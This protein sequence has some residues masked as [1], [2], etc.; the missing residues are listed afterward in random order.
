MEPTLSARELALFPL[1]TVL[2]PGGTLPLQIFEARYLD[3]MSRCLRERGSAPS[4]ARADFGIVHLVAGN[5]VRRAGDDEPRFA[6]IGTSVRIEHADMPRAGLMLVALRG[7]RRFRVGAVECRENGLWIAQASDLPDDPAVAP[8][9][10]HMPV[11]AALRQVLDH[12]ASRA[13]SGTHALDATRFDDAAW[14]AHRWCEL[15]PAAPPQKQAWLEL[16]HPL[17]RLDAVARWLVDQGVTS[18]SA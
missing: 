14:V 12:L 6:A 18:G 10:R 1:Q 5:E 9:P 11:V 2:F 7:L 16:D 4:D 8:A 13:A 17:A 3:L 15:L